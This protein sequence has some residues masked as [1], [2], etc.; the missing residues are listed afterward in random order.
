M[1]FAIDTADHV[2]VMNSQHMKA[3]RHNQLEDNYFHHFK[4]ETLP[5]KNPS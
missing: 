3:R 1:K 4:H 5:L 2:S